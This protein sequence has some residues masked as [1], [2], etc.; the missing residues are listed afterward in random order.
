M[1]LRKFGS[2][3]FTKD[4]TENDEEID[5]CRNLLGT[6]GVYLIYLSMSIFFITMAALTSNIK[7]SVQRRAKI[8]NGFWAWKFLIISGLF[9]GLIK[10]IGSNE[11]FLEIWKWIA[12]GF[13]TLFIF[14]QMTVFVNFAYDWGR[15]WADA[16][17]RSPKRAGKCRWYFAIWFFAILLILGTA[18]A[19]VTIYFIY[20]ETPSGITS[21]LCEQNKWFI[22]GSSGAC[23][24]VLLM[25]LIP[26]GNRATTRSPS[27]GILQV[28]EKINPDKFFYT[29]FF[30][31]FLTPIFFTNFLH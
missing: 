6:T 2:L 10:G 14:W 11:D 21:G 18:G 8:H 23:G 5:E 12:L 27:T 19:Y 7:S 17:H 31:Q 15:S 9:V 3:D 16:A 13:G 30:T 22:L 1:R 4:K 20:T 25:A 24:L 26:C 28:V 29:N